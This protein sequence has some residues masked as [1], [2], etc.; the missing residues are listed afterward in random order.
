MHISYVINYVVHTFDTSNG[1]KGNAAKARKLSDYEALK[2]HIE[3]GYINGYWNKVGDELYGEGDDANDWQYLKARA[4]QTTVTVLGEY[5]TLQFPLRGKDA[6]DNN[7]NP[8]EGLAYYLEQ[9]DV[10]EVINEWDNIMMWERFLL[11]VLG[12]ATTTDETKNVKSPSPI[13]T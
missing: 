1:K 6:V 4:T 12:K 5:I 3:G 7:G 9:A 8:N 13:F 10:R 11:G 2:I